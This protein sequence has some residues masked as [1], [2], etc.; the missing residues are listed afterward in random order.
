MTPDARSLTETSEPASTAP[1]SNI[2]CAALPDNPHNEA[3]ESTINTP[4][5]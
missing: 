5:T 1:L 4:F 3:P 2:Y